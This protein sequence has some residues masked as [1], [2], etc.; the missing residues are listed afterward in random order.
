MDP[1]ALGRLQK[2]QD[3][4]VCRRQ[5][6]AA[7][8][9]DEFI[10]KRLRKHEWACIH[11]GVYVDHTGAPMWLQRA[12][13]AVLYYWPAALAGESALTVA[14][15]RTDVSD[16]VPHAGEPKICVAV[17][18]GRRVARLPG[19]SVRRVRR[20]G[21]RVQPNRQPPRIVLERALLA[22]ASAACTEA[23]AVAVLGDA[24]QTRRTTPRRLAKELD[25]LPTLPRRNLLAAVLDDVASGAYSVLE[26]R[27]LVG[28]ERPHGLPTTARQRRVRVGR[29]N[30]YRDV[31]YLGLATVVELDGRLGGAVLRSQGWSGQLRQCGPGCLVEVGDVPPNTD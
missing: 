28:V 7:G 18:Q 25:Q 5:V 13:A 3:G 27:Y 11:R 10:R 14:G 15:V 23:A 31:E 17:D 21:S 8:L 26:H 29:A 16:R 24:C 9:D 20:L 30:A 2:E 6:L 19:V 12:W 1:A 4:V 22:V